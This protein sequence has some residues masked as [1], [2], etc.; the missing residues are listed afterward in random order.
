MRSGA[1]KGHP[2]AGGRVAGTLNH[3]TVEI[4]ELARIHGPTVIARLVELVR[5]TSGAVAV[6]ASRELL[7][8]GYGKPPQSVAVGGDPNAPPVQTKQTI[9]YSGVLAKLDEKV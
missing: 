3:L 1:K 2:K 9:I 8:R 7:D 5:D 4:K 6:A